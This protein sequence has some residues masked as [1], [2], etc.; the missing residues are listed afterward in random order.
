MPPPADRTLPLSDDFES[1]RGDLGYTAGSRLGDLRNLLVSLGRRSL[2]KDAENNGDPDLEP[3]FDRATVS[4]AVPAVYSRMEIAAPAQLPAQ[5]QF[6]PPQSVSEIEKEKEAARPAAK[7]PRRESWDEDEIQTLP[8]RRGQ[9][10]KKRY[11][12]M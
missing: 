8:S 3:R 9:Y 11:S 6:L 2:N 7:P 12:A 5:P 10:K 1:R 4:P